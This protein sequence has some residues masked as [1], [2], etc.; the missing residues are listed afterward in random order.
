MNFAV[1]KT[2]GKQY[3]VKENK[4]LKVEKLA[5]EVGD[6][7]VFDKVLM[8]ADEAGQKVEIGQPELAG[9]SVEARIMAQGRDRKIRVVKYKNKTRYHKVY[10]HRQCF[11]QVRITKIGGGAVAKKPVEKKAV[12]KKSAVK[13][14]SVKK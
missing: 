6:Q 3:F 12:A 13:K 9:V 10:G 11:T 14:T 5:G 7:I 4:I 2:G 8:L 1:I